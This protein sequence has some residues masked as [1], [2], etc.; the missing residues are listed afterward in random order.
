MARASRRELESQFRRIADIQAELDKRKSDSRGLE[1]TS[2]LRRRDPWIGRLI[3]RE[4]FY[5]QDADPPRWPSHST[6]ADRSRDL[7]SSGS[8]W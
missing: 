4:K 7:S 6:R 5:A 2:D 3:V 8:L 1:A